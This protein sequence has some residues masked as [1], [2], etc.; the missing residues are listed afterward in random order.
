MSFL[1]ADCLWSEILAEK[2]GNAQ[3]L[4]AIDTACLWQQPPWSWPARHSEPVKLMMCNSSPCYYFSNYEGDTPSKE[5]ATWDFPCTSNLWKVTKQQLIENPFRGILNKYGGLMVIWFHIM[6]TW[7]SHCPTQQRVH[8]AF[9]M[10]Q[11]CLTFSAD[12]F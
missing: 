1:K 10:I 3:E 11:W 9:I 8:S 12:S 2:Y 7:N 4:F 5:Q 6:P